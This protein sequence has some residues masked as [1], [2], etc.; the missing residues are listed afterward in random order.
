M[1]HVDT[2]EGFEKLHAIEH[3][4]MLRLAALLLGN[5]SEAEEVVQEAFLVVAEK[6][7]EIENPGGYLRT[8]VIN[9][10]NQLLRRRQ[11][12]ARHPLPRAEDLTTQLPETIELLDA[13][14][15][16]SDRQR[17]AIVLR[18]YL[19]LSDQE[20]ATNLN[21]R[22]SSVRSHLRRGLRIVRKELS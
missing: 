21:C 5:R 15:P 1:R 22:P 7:N 4:A 17:Q 3:Q 12:A 9:G 2:C 6:W 10:S 13:L 19:G 8:A 16:L 18:Y 14:R 20:I 11:T